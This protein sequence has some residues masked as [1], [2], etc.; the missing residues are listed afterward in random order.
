MEDA[1]KFEGEF[2]A[3]KKLLGNLRSGYLDGSESFGQHVGISRGDA[4]RN[5]LGRNCPVQVA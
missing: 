2:Q 4:I 5:F 3:P 1:R